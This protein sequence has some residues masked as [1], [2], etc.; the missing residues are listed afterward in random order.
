MTHNLMN[1]LDSA[2]ALLVP[3]CLALFYHA[4]GK[5]RRVLLFFSA[6][7]IL[8]SCLASTGFLTNTRALPPRMAFVLLPSCLLVIWAFRKLRGVNLNPDFLLALH[9]LRLPVELVLHALCALHLVPRLMTFE[10]YNI[11]ILTGVSAIFLLLYRRLTGRPLDRKIWIA[12]NIAGLLLLLVIIGL[13]VFSVPS[14]L[15]QLA[16]DQPNVAVLVFPYV[17]LPAVIVPLV[18]LSHLLALRRLFSVGSSPAG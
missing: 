10:G 6:W 12:W 2:F 16:F 3:L 9:A 1:L 8:V 13:A 14:P 18:L 4:S 15:Q 11:D 17:L 5:N 7:T